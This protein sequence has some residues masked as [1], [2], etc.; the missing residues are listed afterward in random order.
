M[1]TVLTNN[2]FKSRKDLTSFVRR[3]IA[4]LEDGSQDSDVDFEVC[5]LLTTLDLFL[6][7]LDRSDRP[8]LA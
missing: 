4:E 3:I 1:S 6:A 8:R 5:M 2:S 7:C